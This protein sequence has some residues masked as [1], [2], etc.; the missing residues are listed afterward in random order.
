MCSKKARRPAAVL[1]AAFLLAGLSCEKAETVP[2]GTAT[3]EIYL[4][5]A[6]G[7]YRA[8]R[9]D[10][11][12]LLVTV[13]GG[14]KDSGWTEIPL[15]RTGIYDLAPFGAPDDTLL[16]TRQLPEGS[17]SE[18]RL[19]LGSRNQLVLQDGDTVS[20]N[21]PG[22]L[23]DGVD[24]PVH[25]E[26]TAYGTRRLVLDFDVAHSV[27]QTASD[28]VLT[29]EVR[30]YEKETTGGVEGIVLPDSVLTGIRAIQGTDTL[31]TLAD[32]TGYFRFK[33]LASGTCRLAF[34]TDTAS[35]YPGDTLDNI[36]VAAGEITRLDTLY[37]TPPPP[38]SLA[39]QP[40][41]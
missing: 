1:A 33:G 14:G 40:A 19:V 34:L 3:L 37:L 25:T 13:S 9:L 28:Y 35:G 8:L 26:L 23:Q 29:P 31:H 5:D 32:S 7:A 39:E 12:K 2:Q 36:Q 6:P 27:T 17:V 11:R 38:D 4:T 15:L 21:I 30:S 20:V 16:A 18:M 24:I 22:E 41:P 10:L